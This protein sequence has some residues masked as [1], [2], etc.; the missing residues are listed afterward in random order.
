LLEKAAEIKA[1]YNLSLA[2]A[3]ISASAL[4]SDSIL[5]HKDPEFK[6]LDC[7]Q[8]L[9]PFKTRVNKE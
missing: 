2:D 4:L 8:M 1:T 7:D 9:L 5:V 3:W 6:A